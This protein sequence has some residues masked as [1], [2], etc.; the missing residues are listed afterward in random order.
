M[1]EQIDQI[2]KKFKADTS[3]IKDSSDL[4]EIRIKYL[5]RKGLISYAFQLV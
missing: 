5:G 4:E 1:F 2:K 3:A